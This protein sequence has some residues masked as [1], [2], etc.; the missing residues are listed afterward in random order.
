M[1]S[2]QLEKARMFEEEHGKEIPPHQRPAFHL[3]PYVGWLNDPNGFSY[4]GGKYHLFYQYYPYDSAWGSMHWGHAVSEDLLHWQYLPAALAPDRFYDN[5]G[6]FSG[7]AVELSD[8]RQLLMYTAVHQEGDNP[9]A[10]TQCL[11]IGDG[12]DYEKYEANP[13]LAENALPAG[14]SR[15]DFRDPKMWRNRDGSFGCVAVNR[16]EDGSGQ[17][18]LYESPDGLHWKFKSVL[19]KNN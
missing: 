13:V 10:Q 9:P 11:A 5:A 8:G 16:A 2:E 3:T 1:I 17:V 7:S 14:G 15:V 6:C 19:I 4:Y 12:L 18:L